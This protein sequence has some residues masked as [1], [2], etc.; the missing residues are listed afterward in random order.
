MA[1]TQIGRPVVDILSCVA[2][3]DFSKYKPAKALIRWSQDHSLT[4]LQQHEMDQACNLIAKINKAL[5]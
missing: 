4:D 2:K 1:G 5:S 3:K